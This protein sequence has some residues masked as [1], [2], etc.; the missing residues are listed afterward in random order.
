MA[1]KLDKKTKKD[2][3]KAEVK[4]KEYKLEVTKEELTHLR[5]LMSVV[6]SIE[7]EET[8]SAALSEVENRADSEVSLWDKV[9]TA[10]MKA[11]IDIGD[12]APNLTIAPKD[13]PPLSV[14]HYVLDENA[15]KDQHEVLTCHIRLDKFC[16]SFRQ[17]Q[18]LL[19]LL[20]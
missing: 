10:C 18:R 17:N 1:K 12:N 9:A 16:T 19:F 6:L 8:L 2:K 20:K 7:N 11:S 14:F 15:T 4:E 5:D 3:L 13:F